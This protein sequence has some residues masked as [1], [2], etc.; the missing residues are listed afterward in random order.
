MSLFG[1][2]WMLLL[3]KLLLSL[4]SK[5]INTQMNSYHYSYSDIYP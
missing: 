5:E 1:Y 3:V 2:K 4:Y